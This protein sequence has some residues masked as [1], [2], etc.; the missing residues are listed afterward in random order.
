MVT[1]NSAYLKD[2]LDKE[3]EYVT[4]AQLLLLNQN[5][6]QAAK[7]LEAGRIKKVI[8]IDDETKEESLVSVVKD[9]EKR[10]ALA[11]A[12]MERRTEGGW[13]RGS[14]VQRAR[15]GSETYFRRSGRRAGK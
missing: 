9:S 2:L 5:P 4:L 7:V 8:R 14:W 1:L 13:A 10:L 15:K 6:Y 3:T 11:R 12:A